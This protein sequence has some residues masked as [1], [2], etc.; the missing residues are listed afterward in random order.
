MNKAIGGALWLGVLAGLWAAA[1][2]VSIGLNALFRPGYVVRDFGTEYYARLGPNRV[3]W[4]DFKPYRLQCAE[5]ERRV[6]VLHTHEFDEPVDAF[7]ARRFP[8]CPRRQQ[9]NASAIP[10]LFSGIL[11][12]RW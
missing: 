10:S 5:G 1:P 12:G 4:H 7:L 8:E 11:V 9:D 3:Y 2:V 6:V